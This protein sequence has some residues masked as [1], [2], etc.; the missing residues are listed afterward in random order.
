MLSELV[1]AG[2]SFLELGSKLAG[3]VELSNRLVELAE[4]TELTELN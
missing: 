1:G 3:L 2:M 4:L